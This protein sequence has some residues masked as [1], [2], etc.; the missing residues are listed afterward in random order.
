VLCIVWGAA[1]AGLAL[2]APRSQPS[3]L[4]GEVVE[5]ERAL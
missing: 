2:A 4:G 3:E 5:A 1:V